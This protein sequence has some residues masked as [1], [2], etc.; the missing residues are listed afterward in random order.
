MT[1]ERIQKLLNRLENLMARH[2]RM[3]VAAEKQG[4]EIK[5]SYW[6]GR[7]EGVNDVWKLLEPELKRRA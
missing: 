5:Q 3:G 4:S 6:D 7:S 1:K 2:S